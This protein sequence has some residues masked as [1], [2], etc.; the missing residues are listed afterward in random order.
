MLPKVNN[1]IILINTGKSLYAMLVLVTKHR[2]PIT[3]RT[4]EFQRFEPNF[5]SLFLFEILK[6]NSKTARA[7]ITRE[8]IRMGNILIIR[9]KIIRKGYIASM[10]LHNIRKIFLFLSSTGTFSW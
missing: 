2:T 8:N 9:K 1:S 4:R 3:K 6:I 10:V 7:M 5:L